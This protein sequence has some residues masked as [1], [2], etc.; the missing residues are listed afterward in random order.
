M[1]CQQNNSDLL[2]KKRT[3][4]FHETIKSVP[5]IGKIAIMVWFI[6]FQIRVKKAEKRDQFSP[7]DERGIAIPPARL[8]HRVHGDLDRENFLRIG[9]TMANDIRNSV[10]EVDRDWHSFT[11][12]LDFGCGCGRVMRWF[13]GLENNAHFYGTDI[14]PDSVGW[15]KENIPGVDWRTNNS[16]PPTEYSDDTF[17]LVYAISVF[18]H[19]DE[20]YQN[21]WLGE[22]RRITR[23]GGILIL[24]VHGD[25]IISNTPLVKAQRLELEKKGFLFVTG[26]VGKFKIDGLP[27]FYQTAY[28]K[29]EYISREWNNY[30]EVVKQIHEYMRQDMVILRR[31]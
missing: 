28:H 24:T 5:V 25:N 12:I 17:D 14:D 20:E 11:N 31:R 27:D 7:I 15:C 13:I 29:S 6:F 19:L 21:A 23:S 1:I 16:T 3:I 22:L 9:K 2:K 26:P 8:R 4:L 10:K 30:F 18:T